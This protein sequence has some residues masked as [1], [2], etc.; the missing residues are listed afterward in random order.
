[1]HRTETHLCELDH[2][3]RPAPHGTI[4]PQCKTDTQEWLD[5]VTETHL[6]ELLLIAR[7]EAQPATRNRINNK[8]NAPQDALNIAVWSL[9]Y[10]LAHKW[11]NKIQNLTKNKNAVHLIEDIQAGVNTAIRLTE[12]EDEQAIDNA[13]IQKRMNQIFPMRPKDMIPYLKQHLG[14]R[15]TKHQFTNWQRHNKIKPRLTNN[16]GWKFY[17]PADVL[18]AID[19]DRRHD[20]KQYLY[21]GETA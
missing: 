20:Y 11:P 1:M 18:R 6:I 13:Y 16:Q 15:I 8:S 7:R 14:V 5:H 4:C 12:G 9:W 3:D 19:E 17:H 21:I 2:C 10:D